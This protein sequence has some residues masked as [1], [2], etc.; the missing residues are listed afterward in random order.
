ML[1]KEEVLAVAKL[2]RLEL[3]PEKEKKYHRQLEEVLGLFKKIEGLK[4]SGVEETSQVTKLKNIC[5]ADVVIYDQNLRPQGAKENF[6]NV[7][8]TDSDMIIVPQTI[9]E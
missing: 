4:L 3:S 1:K 2:A 7:P 5:Q 6:S 8:K 9:K